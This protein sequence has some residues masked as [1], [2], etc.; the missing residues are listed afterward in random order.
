VAGVYESDSKYPAHPRIHASLPYCI[1]LQSLLA[2]PK[3]VL[4]PAIVHV[5]DY[6]FATAQLRYARLTFQSLQNYSYLRIAAI[7]AGLT[8]A[9]ILDYL[10]VS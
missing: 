2:L 10:S 3:K 9:D 5:A 8:L 4:A 7:E 6:S 1:S